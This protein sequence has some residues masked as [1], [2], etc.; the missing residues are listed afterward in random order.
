MKATKRLIDSVW[1]LEYEVISPTEAEIIR[2]SREDMDGYRLE[3]ELP[4]CA[5]VQNEERIANKILIRKYEPFSWVD[6]K[7]ADAIYTVI[8]PKHIFDY[9]G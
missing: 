9:G 5:I 2:Y 8:N 3:R 7:N 6:E 1:T 4:Q